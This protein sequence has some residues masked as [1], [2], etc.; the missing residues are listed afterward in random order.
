[1]SLVDRLKP[2]CLPDSAY[3]SVP[4]RIVEDALLTSRLKT[5]IGS[6]EYLYGKS[7]LSRLLQ[8]WSY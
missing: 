4:D 2:Y 6:V 7:L 1:M 8:V 3:R 5:V